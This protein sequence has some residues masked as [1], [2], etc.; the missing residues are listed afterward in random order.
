MQVL[1]DPYTECIERLKSQKYHL[2]GAHS[3]VKKCLWVH[4]ALVYGR[5]CYK[6]RFYGIASHRCIQMSPSVLWCWNNCLHC[7]RVRPQDLGLSSEGLTT[8]PHVDD[9]E[10]IVEMAIL[11]HRRIVSGYRR[12]TSEEMFREALNPK[13]VA[14]SLTGEPTLYPRLSEL[15]E[16]FHRRGLTTFLVSRGV[17]PDI[18][19]SLEEE[20]SQ[21]YISIEAYDRETYNYF[22]RPLIPNA[23]E[24]TLKTLE[25]L[26]SFTSP[27]VI[28][29]TLVKGFNMSYEAIKKFKKLLELAQPTYI[30]TKAYMHVGGSVGRLGRENMPSFNE[31]MEFAKKLSDEVGYRIA[32]HSIASRV[33]LLTRLTKPIRVGEG[34]PRGWEEVDTCEEEIGEY[35]RVEEAI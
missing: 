14:I 16:E 5:F 4:N 12:R 28:R 18:L 17:R 32:S 19:A 31:V 8:L 9:P 25:I 7:W 20:P 30:E 22:N 15:I 13:H 21:L 23:W 35:S 34:C 11:E 10:F 29:I 6:C 24:L 33:V 3:A 26:P 27:T 1:R 2:I